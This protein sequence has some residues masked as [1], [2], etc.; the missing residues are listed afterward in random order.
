MALWRAYLW[1]RCHDGIYRWEKL[2]KR[3]QSPQEARKGGLRA[4]A[5]ANQRHPHVW[6]VG[7]VTKVKVMAC[8]SEKK[9]DRPK[10][11]KRDGRPQ[12]SGGIAPRQGV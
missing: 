4:M 6:D 9:R 2:R 12:E 11:G 1:M 5:K 8:D 10:A 3:Y 7:R